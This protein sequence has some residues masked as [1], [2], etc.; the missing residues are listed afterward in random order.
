MCDFG[1]LQHQKKKSENSSMHQLHGWPRSRNEFALSFLHRYW[2]FYAFH[3]IRRHDRRAR[4]R[5]FDGNSRKMRTVAVVFRMVYDCRT[6]GPPS[7]DTG[8][9]IIVCGRRKLLVIRVQFRQRLG[10]ILRV[11][12]LI[13]C[14]LVAHFPAHGW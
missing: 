6:A 2:A 5:I 1:I 7:L 11:Y 9:Q 13:G 12:Y 8:A 14:I 10:Q 3:C 4:G